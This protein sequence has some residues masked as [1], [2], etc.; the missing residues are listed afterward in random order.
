MKLAASELIVTKDGAIYHLNLRPDQIAETVFLVGDPDRVPKVSKHFDRI[1]H[2]V[3]KREFVTHTGW[4]GGQRLSVVST[5]IGPDNIDIVL[6]EL[7]A[8]FNIDFET[9][10]VKET[11]TTL[12][13]VRLGTSGSLSAQLPPDSLVISVF[14]I[15]LDN[16]LHFYKS[17]PDS[18]AAALAEAFADFGQSLG[19]PLHPHASAAD[20]GLV[21]KLGEG[22]TKGITLTCPGFY[23]PQGRQLR[24][25]SILHDGFFDSIGQFRFDGL[26]VTN[27]EMETAAIFGL[28]HLLGHRAASCNG[29]LANR[30]TGHFTPDPK[31]LEEK[32]IAQV[33][34]R[35]GEQ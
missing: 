24:L 29:I 25:G 13:L 28:A 8:L 3:Q 10:T 26:A 1:E 12:N 21:E 5:G 14:G 6:N 27:F 17:E 19:I 33:L 34:Q 4:L 18:R 22:M 32:L 9:R 23:A 35:V 20:L 31:A 16:L 30:I 11:L 15:G 7:D 2:R